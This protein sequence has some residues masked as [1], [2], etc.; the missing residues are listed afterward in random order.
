MWRCPSAPAISLAAASR[1]APEA[2]V[3][4][5][6]ARLIT[7]HGGC[8]KRYRQSN[9]LRGPERV[10]ACPGWTTQRPNTKNH[11]RCIVFRPVTSPSRYDLSP[12]RK[13]ICSMKLQRWRSRQSTWRPCELVQAMPAEPPFHAGLCHVRRHRC[14]LARLSSRIVARPCG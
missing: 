12:Y 9:N 5:Q 7:P 14:C 2:S 8:A 1:Q 11:A 4:P 6:P 13:L 10:N 3:I